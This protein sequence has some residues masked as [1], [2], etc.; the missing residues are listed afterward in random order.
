VNGV[1]WFLV[2]A[3]VG[4]DL[5]IGYAWFELRRINH[6]IA[7]VNIAAANVKEALRDLGEPW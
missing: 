3:F 6:S 2:G 7:Q 1:F 5:A 4:F